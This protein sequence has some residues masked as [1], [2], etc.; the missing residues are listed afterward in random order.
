[1]ERYI[2]RVRVEGMFDSRSELVVDFS[3]TDNCIF[4][5]NGSGK[6]VLIN[7][8]VA[9]IQCDI[10]ALSKLPFSSIRVITSPTG[11]KKEL[12]FFTVTKTSF[13]ATYVFHEDIAVETSAWTLRQT[14]LATEVTKD[15]PYK[16]YT[17]QTRSEDNL[18]RKFMLKRLIGAIIPFT[19]IP[20]LRIHDTVSHSDSALHYEMRRQRL[21]EREIS[22]VLDPNIRVLKGLQEEFSSRY[23]AAQTRIASELESLK[24]SIFEKLLFVG[25]GVREDAEEYVSKFMSSKGKGEDDGRRADDVVSQIKDLNLDIPE[26]KVRKHFEIWGGMKEALLNAYD[27]HSKNKVDSNDFSQED[28]KAYSRAYFNLI[29][30]VPQFKTFDEAIKLI[31]DVQSRKGEWLLNFNNFKREVNSFLPQGKEFEFGD[32]G[33][34]VLKNSG[35]T[36]ELNDLSSGEKHI[37]AILGRVCLSSFSGSSVFIA[38]EPELSLHLEWQRK[39][40]PSIRR[41][42]PDTQVIVATHAPAIISEDANKIN[43]RKCYKDE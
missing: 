34:F 13:G 18:T 35:N 6:T 9:S 11:G 37:L 15:K 36:L 17:R 30:S 38:D 32:A 27:A 7:L 16:V 4:G 23:T 20:L 24:T 42:S 22:E 26:V 39:I 10:E 1:M 40:L 14:K 29:A 28:F 3:P 33:Q 8:I 21:S 41:L 25:E 31:G 43:L 12:S 5:I 19:Y 2:K